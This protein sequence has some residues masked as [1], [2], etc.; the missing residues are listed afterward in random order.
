MNCLKPTD[1]YGHMQAGCPSFHKQTFTEVQILSS[2]PGSDIEQTGHGVWS[3]EVMSWWKTPG[4][5][6]TIRKIKPMEGQ[7][8]SHTKQ[9]AY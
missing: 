9:D 1:T 7:Y 8:T 5:T 3:H 4:R 2:V 6:Q